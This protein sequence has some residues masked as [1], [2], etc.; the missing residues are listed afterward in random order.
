MDQPQNDDKDE[1]YNDTQDVAWEQRFK[2][3]K[4]QQNVPNHEQDAMVWPSQ[5]KED[6]STTEENV[7]WPSQKTP[8]TSQHLS[9]NKP[10]HSSNMLSDSDKSDFKQMQEQFKVFSDQQKV[11][12]E[13]FSKFS[14]VV[15]NLNS[16]LSEFED[17]LNNIKE[18]QV[19]IQSE[20]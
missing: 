8:D 6:K 14:G 12:F 15:Q 3:L 18:A 11:M 20:M 13:Q 9:E 5:K 16:R 2:R 19:Q 7:M 10:N 1:I 4:N 17:N